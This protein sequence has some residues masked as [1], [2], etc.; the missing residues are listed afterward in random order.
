MRVRDL[1]QKERVIEDMQSDERD[2]DLNTPVLVP[3]SKSG[4]SPSH[5]E[6]MS[7]PVPMLVRV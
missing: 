5:N 4:A 6:A 2:G 7:L 3:A 1:A